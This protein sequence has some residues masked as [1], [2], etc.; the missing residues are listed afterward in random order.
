MHEAS[1][2]LSLIDTLTARCME[3]GYG[4]IESVRL[5]I[6]MASGILPEAIVFAFEAAKTDTI[7]RNAELI[8]DLVP[9]GGTCNECRKDFEVTE[10]YVLSCPICGSPSFRISK[11]YELDVV[12]M[13]VK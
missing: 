8:I 5:K 11:G 9:L 2:V 1:I 13:D 6:G 10:A 4:S 12:E 3:E 7:A